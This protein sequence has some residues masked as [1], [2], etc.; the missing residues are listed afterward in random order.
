VTELLSHLPPNF[1]FSAAG[2]AIGHH[3]IGRLKWSSGPPDGPAAVTGMDVAHFEN[4]RIHS[5]YVFL[6]TRGRLST[7][8]TK[9]SQPRRYP[10]LKP[11]RP[12]SKRYFAPT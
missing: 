8:F 10:W 12:V 11:Q 7:G 6:E 1:V 9:P 3:N 4:G 5:L 2:Q